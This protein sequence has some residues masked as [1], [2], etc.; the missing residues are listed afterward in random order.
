M[1]DRTPEII[2]A[3]LRQAVVALSKTSDPDSRTALEALIRAF[4]DE[5]ERAIELRD[6]RLPE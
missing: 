5:H 2:I 4:A 3:E 1:K 6:A